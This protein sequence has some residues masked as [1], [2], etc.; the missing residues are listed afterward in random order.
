LY[1]MHM[2]QDKILSEHTANLSRSM[3]GKNRY[4]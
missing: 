4:V 2:M 3:I 1:R